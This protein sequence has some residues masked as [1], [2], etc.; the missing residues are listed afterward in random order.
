ME[1]A[2]VELSTDVQT[3]SLIPQQIADQIE[4]DAQNLDIWV[5][6]TPEGFLY[7]DN[8]IP[9]VV[10]RIIE[11]TPHWVKWENKKPQRVYEVERPSEDYERR[12]DLKIESNDGFIIRL[13]LPN[14][15]YRNFCAFYKSVTGQ[16]HEI[17][18]VMTCLKTKE[19]NGSFGTFVVV[20]FS[21]FDDVP[22]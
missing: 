16:G 3:N 17:S 15:S 2:V 22:F 20:T 18:S 7:S 11:I 6:P 19:V 5:K 21:Y 4:A 12:C 8:V 14:S 9:Q 10:G 13:S 1:N